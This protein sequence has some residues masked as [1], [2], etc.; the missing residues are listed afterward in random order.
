ME[1]LGWLLVTWGPPDH[2][3]E[4]PSAH[5]LVG[6]TWS[7]IQMNTTHK[8]QWITPIPFFILIWMDCIVWSANR[9]FKGETYG[10]LTKGLGW[11]GALYILNI[12]SQPHLWILPAPS[13]GKLGPMAS[14]TEEALCTSCTGNR[15]YICVRVGILKNSPF[16]S[17]KFFWVWRPP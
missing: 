1:F 9:F 14:C 7:P 16:C 2:L 3:F 15:P 17:S 12:G 13:R 6:P 10:V 11:L 4:S 5:L 8:A